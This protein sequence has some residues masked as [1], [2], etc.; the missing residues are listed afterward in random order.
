MRE[1]PP[2]GGV[3]I[4]QR[5]PG[6]QVAYL[7]G[8]VGVVTEIQT[9]TL[10]EITAL[11]A[12]GGVAGC[13]SVPISCLERVEDVLP[14]QE[15]VFW[16]DRAKQYKRD[17]EKALAASVARSKAWQDHV[18]KVATKYGVSIMTA[19]NLYA[20]LQEFHKFN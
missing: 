7:E 13:G 2:M 1:C 6:N 20:D 15:A 18:E 12:T 4:I 5:Q 16:H 17:R 14:A 3:V 19:L 10:V 9:D 8:E 11:R